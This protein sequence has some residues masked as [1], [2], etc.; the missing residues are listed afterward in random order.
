[1]GAALG[2]LYAYENA[3]RKAKAL[4]NYDLHGKLLAK[5]ISAALYH[6]AGKGTRW[7]MHAEQRLTYY[8]YY[9]RLDSSR[10][11]DHLML[12]CA[13]ECRLAPLPGA[14]NNNKPG[15]KL[16]SC[17]TVEGARVPLTILEAVCKQTGV[18]AASRKGR[19]SVYWG[20]QVRV[21]R[22]GG[23]SLAVRR[24]RRPHWLIMGFLMPRVC[25]SVCGGV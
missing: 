7:V 19:L 12:L 1:M 9:R 8:C 11:V 4:F 25:L 5:E 18:Y 10:R 24:G 20:D 15:V 22:A 2:T 14:E 23:L 16:P 17:L 3:V 21:W 6:T 13:D